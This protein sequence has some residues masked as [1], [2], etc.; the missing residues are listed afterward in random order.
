MDHSQRGQQ[1]RHDRQ[2]TGGIVVS[3]Q[4]GVKELCDQAIAAEEEIHGA[5][6][7]AHQADGKDD[8]VDGLKEIAS[9]AHVHSPA[10][11][12][13]PTHLALSPSSKVV[14]AAGQEKTA[15]C[16]SSFTRNLTRNSARYAMRPAIVVI[17]MTLASVTSTAAAFRRWPNLPNSMGIWATATGLWYFGFM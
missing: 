16:Q 13:W 12:N 14:D 1:C 5:P 11:G 10:K 9:P 2:K 7:A 4:H 3:D 15:S 8:G 17:W 6:D